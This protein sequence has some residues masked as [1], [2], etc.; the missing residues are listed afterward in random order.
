MSRELR[1][2]RGFVFVRAI[3]DS[4]NSIMTPV[5]FHPREHLPK[6]LLVKVCFRYRVLFLLTQ[7]EIP[8]AVAWHRGPCPLPFLSGT[9]GLEVTDIL[10]SEVNQ[11]SSSRVFASFA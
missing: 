8:T 9:K 2:S 3:G 5:Q 11:S 4:K 10:F 7:L 1:S 6:A